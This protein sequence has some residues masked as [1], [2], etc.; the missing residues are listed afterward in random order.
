MWTYEKSFVCAVLNDL[1]KCFLI[2]FFFFHLHQ[3]LLSMSRSV[4]LYS[5][6]YVF[7]SAGLFL[8]AYLCF[9]ESPFKGM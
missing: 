8:N 6:M 3:W 9:R 1:M 2:F 4:Y 5:L 7:L